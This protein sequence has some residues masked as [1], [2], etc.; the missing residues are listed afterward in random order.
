MAKLCKSV[1]VL[2]FLKLT[3]LHSWF[4]NYH[5]EKVPSAVDRY[6]N[7]IKRVSGVLDGHLKD[8]EYLVGDKC[9]YADLAFVTWQ[10]GIK[11]VTAEK[12]DEE[13]EFP[14]LSAW[15]KRLT[16]RE[17]TS[18]VLEQKKTHETKVFAQM[19]KEKEEAEKK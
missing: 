10:I 1:L 15:L 6:V 5:P 2:K 13:K 18:S 16:S 19:R 14:N 17:A 9:T 11:R 3:S 7:E 8:R 12:Y 4:E